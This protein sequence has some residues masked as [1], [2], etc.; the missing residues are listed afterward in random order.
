MRLVN[1]TLDAAAER[2]ATAVSRF[3]ELADRCPPRTMVDAILA[4]RPARIIPYRRAAAVQAWLKICD[5]FDAGRI[6]R[7]RVYMDTHADK[8]RQRQTRQLR[9]A[10]VDVP[11]RN[12]TQP[13]VGGRFA[14]AA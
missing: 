10:G 2:E 14:E 4:K 12:S 1:D 8:Q 13:R 7:V 9:L 11:K 6:P 5:A 3:Y